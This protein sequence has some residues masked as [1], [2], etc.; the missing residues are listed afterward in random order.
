M[1]KNKDGYELLK[2]Y[3]NHIGNIHSYVEISL[4]HIHFQRL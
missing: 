2:M 1:G 3:G 4:N